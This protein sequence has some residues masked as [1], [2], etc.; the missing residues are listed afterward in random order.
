MLAAVLYGG[1]EVQEELVQRTGQMTAEA[2]LHRAGHYLSTGN[3]Q[4]AE[5]ICREVIARTA[6]H[7]GAHHLLGMVLLRMNRPEE[8]CE[9]VQ[10]VLAIN[11]S[12]PSAHANL[13]MAQRALGRLAEALESFDRALAQAPDFVAVLI[14]R[15]NLLLDLGRFEAALDSFTRAL[16]FE[17]R[18]VYALNGC[19]NARLELGAA[20]QALNDFDRA[21]LELPQ[22]AWL[23]ANRATAL[24]NA[25]RPSESLSACDAVLAVDPAN[26]AAHHT[27][28][29][30]L[31]DL[32]HFPEA[33]AAY[34][35]ALKLEPA[36]ARAWY[37][38]GRAQIYDNQWPE[39]VV[40]YDH[41]LQ[42]AEAR[43]GCPAPINRTEAWV[44]R[45]SALHLLGQLTAAQDS[46]R[47]ALRLEPGHA[48]AHVNLAQTLLL[49]GDFAGGWREYE[50]RW[51]AKKGEARRHESHPLWLG[52]APLDGTS[53]LLHAEQGFGD[54]LQFCRFATTLAERGAR[55]LLEVQEPLH[56]LL[57]SLLGVT[58]VF[59]RGQPLPPFQYQ[60]PL[61]S[62]PLCLRTTVTDIPART[63]YLRA[64][65]HR[66]RDWQARMGP[67]ERL[68]VG[69]VWSGG[70]IQRHPEHWAVSRRRNL[71]LHLLQPLANA[72]VEFYSLQKGEAAEAEWAELRSQAW[73]G[74]QLID[75]T[76]QLQDFSD[77]AALIENLD[78][79][80]SVDT[81]TAHLAGALGKPVWILNRFDSCWRWLLNRTDT[82]WYPTARL[83]RQ[84][85]PGKWQEP[86]LQIRDDLRQLSGSWNGLNTTA[87]KHAG[88]P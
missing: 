39:A 5:S 76:S 19:G 38:R 6:G 68:R 47:R 29:D 62:L 57:Q 61:L 37:N 69:L 64:D 84:P 9:H 70:F 83:Y 65:A 27:R 1:A 63:P 43:R 8:A 54:T 22:A 15:G 51:R 71:P 45:G 13:G 30:A 41:A 77:T 44:N 82:P 18:N 73:D 78:L 72:Q 26:A 81:A 79:V 42:L 52:D 56:G 25:G 20:L 21:L 34:D 59:A 12:D 40:S 49:G 58:A 88:L 11:P 10:T 80:I 16:Q 74:P 60:C 33:V 23:Q 14:E 32:R 50:W 87:V 4:A 3:C 28:G 35:R 85:A 7:A 86:I 53:L 2:N 66:V 17:P 75:W 67:A 46:F 48:E 31:Q 55:V 36:R 24:A